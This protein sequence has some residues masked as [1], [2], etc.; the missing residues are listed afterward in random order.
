LPQRLDYGTA[1][2]LLVGAV[3]FAWGIA[4]LLR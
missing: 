4:L 2:A 1:A 3:A